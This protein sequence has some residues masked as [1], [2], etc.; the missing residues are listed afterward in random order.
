MSSHE[1]LDGLGVPE[2]ML[3]AGLAVMVPI[4]RLVAASR[5]EPCVIAY[6]TVVG[7]AGGGKWWLDVY[8][9]IDT[10]LPQMYD[11]REILGLPAIGLTAPG[12]P[13]ATVEL[14]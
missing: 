10:P 1:H 8:C 5:G 14:R 7:P 9:G 12:V 6:A 4:G 3:R 13:P 2:A 11:P